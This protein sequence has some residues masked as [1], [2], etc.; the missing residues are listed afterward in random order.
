MKVDEIQIVKKIQETLKS[1]QHPLLKKSIVDLNMIR[2][3]EFQSGV[4][5]LKLTQLSPNSIYNHQVEDSVRDALAKISEITDLQISLNWEVS[6]GKSAQNSSLPG[7]K[8]IVAVASGKGGVGKSTVALNLAL[9]LSKSGA[10]VGVLDTDIYGPSLPTLMGLKNTPPLI[11]GEKKKMLPLEKFGIKTMSIG[12]LIK[13]E[14]AAVWRGPMIGRMVQ[15]FVQDVLW[16]DLDYLILDLPPGTGDIQLSL[17]QMLSITGAVIVTTPQDVALADVIRSIAMFQKVQIPILG[18]V[19]NMSYFSCPK[20]HEISHIFGQGGG[21]KKAKNQNI[22]FL[23]SIPLDNR[24]CEASDLGKPIL[25]SDLES[26]QAQ[27]FL[28]LA[29]SVSDQVCLANDRK[30]EIKL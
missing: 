10:K 21:E 13:D 26:E 18:M 22:P 25:E 29:S 5:S 11:D 16:G 1:I 6:G 14:D 12:Y 19:E 24:I 30:I 7:V 3:L 15:Q 23:G 17:S 2:H 28:S 9:A 8:N 4:L 20:C 27:K